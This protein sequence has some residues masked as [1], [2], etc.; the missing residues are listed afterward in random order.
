MKPMIAILTLSPSLYPKMGRAKPAAYGNFGAETNTPAT[1]QKPQEGVRPRS[2][3][4]TK[5]SSL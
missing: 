4:E 1:K 3:A 5:P 2:E